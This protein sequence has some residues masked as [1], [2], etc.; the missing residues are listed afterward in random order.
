MNKTF[1]ATDISTGDVAKI[2]VFTDTYPN[3]RL[4]Y[5]GYITRLN[6]KYSTSKN[7]IE[8]QMIGISSIMNFI[9]FNQGAS[10]SFNKNQDPAQ[11]IKDVI[12]YFNTQYTAGWFSYAGGHIANFGS[13]ISLD[14]YYR[15]CLNSIQ[16]ATSPTTY[17]W[18]IGA[19]GEFW[20]QPTP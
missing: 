3:G 2:T 16:G 12:D 14:F 8:Y 17:W 4:I 10:Y 11:T 1:G 20:F 9:Y 18:R 7:V 6:R 13:S 19:D 5:T 15:K